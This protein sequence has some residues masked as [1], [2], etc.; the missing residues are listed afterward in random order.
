MDNIKEI[1]ELKSKIA[2]VITQLEH[3]RGE[4]KQLSEE[5]TLLKKQNNVCKFELSELQQQFQTLKTAKSITASAKDVHDT[6]IRVNGIVREI[7][8]CIS[9]LNK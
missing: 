6:K 7:D 2:A 9:M 8:K 5:N 4:N 3:Y 1:S